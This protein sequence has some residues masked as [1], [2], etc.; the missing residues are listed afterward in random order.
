MSA[1]KATFSPL[2]RLFQNTSEP[3]TDPLLT[4]I[5]TFIV[6]T[7]AVALYSI[8]FLQTNTDGKIHDLRGIPFVT[9]WTFFTKR[10][11]F[12]RGHFERTGGEMFR[13]R[14]LHVRC[15]DFLPELFNLGLLPQHR[16]IALSGEKARK[17]FFDDKNLDLPQGYRI[18][19]GG[20]PNLECIDVGKAEIEREESKKDVLMLVQKDRLIEGSSSSFHL[21]LLHRVILLFSQFVLFSLMI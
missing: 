8:F 9:A 5:T 11:D 7:L 15:L 20:S 12:I 3:S 16:V 13:F 19:M 2:A 17:I 4:T 10:W 18:L 6:A 1:F 21:S 14:V